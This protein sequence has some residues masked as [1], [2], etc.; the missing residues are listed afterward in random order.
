MILLNWNYRGLENPTAIRDLC[1]LAKDKKP[2]LLFFIETRRTNL[3]MEWIRV[4]LGFENS[5]VV[6]S[7]GRSRGLALMWK[8]D[9]E[10]VIQNY[11]LCHINAVVKSSEEGME[12]KLTDFYGNLEVAKRHEGWNLLKCLKNKAPTPWLCVGDFNEIVSMGEKWG[13][14]DKRD[15]Q[16]EQFRIT[17]EKCELCDLCFIGSKYTWSNAREDGSFLKEHLDRALAN[18]E[19]CAWFQEVEVQVLATRSSDHKPLLVNFARQKK[20]RFFLKKRFKF[21]AKWTLE[22]YNE[23]VKEAWQSAHNQDRGGN[24]V[25]SKL[26]KCSEFLSQWSKKFGSTNIILKEKTAKLEK[27]QQ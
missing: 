27:L 15:S 20:N 1:L 8:E 2:N 26:V 6:D 13:G 14:K 25:I 18:T 19:W 12:W 22:E 4:K 10:L 21:E 11:S 5:F 3:E 23:I 16:M 7:I 9:C 24:H 17:L